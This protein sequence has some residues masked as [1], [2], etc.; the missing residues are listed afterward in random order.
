M[1]SQP[2]SGREYP[3]FSGIKT[4]FRLPIAIGLEDC[5]IAMV[6]IPYD[7][8]VSYRPGTRFAPSRI[9]EV[10]S[11][12]RGFHWEH[13]IHFM[14]ELKVLDFGDCP[15]V[16]IDPPQCYKKIED[17]FSQ[18]T[19]KAQKFIGIGGD[20]SITLPILRAVKKKYGSVRLIHFDA[21]LDTYPA[22]WGCEYH[23]GSFFRHAVQEGLIQPEISLQI[24]IRGPL[25]GEED[26]DFVKKHKVD[27]L[28]VDDIR[29]SGLQAFLKNR[30]KPFDKTP[31]YISFDYPQEWLDTF[32]AEGYHLQ[33]RVLQE[34]FETFE[35][36]NWQEVMKKYDAGS[37]QVDRQALD[38]GLT[39]G[40]VY[41]VCNRDLTRATTF[42]VAGSR[43]ENCTRSRVILKYIIPHLSGA[44]KRVLPPATPFTHKDPSLTPRE[45][46]V[47]KWLKEGKSSWDVSKILGR[48]EDAVNFHIKNITRKLN[49]MNRTHAVAIALQKGLIEM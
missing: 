26:L 18:L 33:D 40:F 12:G 47:L 1:K 45:I 17:Y 38:Y 46:E 49:A 7:G 25:A 44:L 27:V 34:F 39:D 48:S 35:L 43:I 37:D 36:L 9:R 20:H 29:E 3:R 4:F 13:Q 28:T 16:P 31:T 21:H 15:T 14:K 32:F 6:G 8:S 30:I 5:D 23:H 11:L 24:G 41:G 10:S 42:F 22:A 2:L 19:S